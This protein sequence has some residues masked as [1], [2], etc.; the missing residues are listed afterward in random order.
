[1]GSDHNRFER[2]RCS[3]EHRSGRL[4]SARQLNYLASVA[5]WI[6][7]HR[8]ISTCHPWRRP[9]PRPSSRAARTP[10]PRS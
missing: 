10:T 8:T 4:A 2:A 6:R 7:A 9:P 3:Q 1:M 5:R